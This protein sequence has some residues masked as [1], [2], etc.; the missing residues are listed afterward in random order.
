LYCRNAENTV[1]IVVYDESSFVHVECGHGDLIV[2]EVCIKKVEDLVTG[3]A[4][5]KSVN[6]G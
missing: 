6:I 1:D 4:V 3:H 5:D 2:T